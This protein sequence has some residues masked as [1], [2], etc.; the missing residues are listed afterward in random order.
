MNE[1]TLSVIIPAYNA[2]KYLGDAVASV[3]AQRWAGRVEIL[4]I[5]DGS[6]D[7]TAAIAEGLGCRVIGKER[8]GAASA[9]NM[10]VRGTAGEWILFL[11]A[12]DVLRPDALEALYA[13]FKEQPETM[14]V[15]GR[16][17]DFVSP[18]LT[19]AQKSSLKTREGSYDGV[20]PGCALI[21]RSVFEQLGLF[22]ETLKSGETVD[23][24]MRLRASALATAKIDAVTLDRRLHLTNTGRF[25]RREEML[26]YAALLRKRMKKT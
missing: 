23:W 17:A 26:N 21:R 18:E 25:N 12:D 19:E 15:F 14:A 16:A 13:P 2:G 22:D 6:S 7:S 3:R 1:N 10:G 5:D 4:V 24:L 8:G 11:D 20:L 9:R